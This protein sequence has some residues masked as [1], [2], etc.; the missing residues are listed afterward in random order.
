M[1]TDK[2]KNKGQI[3]H[4]EDDFGISMQ[5]IS[6]MAV[7]HCEV[8]NWSPS[9]AVRI[10][11]KIGDLIREHRR[12]GYGISELEDQKHSKWLRL[13]GFEKYKNKWILDDDGQ[14]KIV[15]IWIRRYHD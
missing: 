1:N 12:D 2:L 9:V 3:L 4:L 10:H 8:N 13:M 6:G 14:D 15:T 11:R 5:D 7:S